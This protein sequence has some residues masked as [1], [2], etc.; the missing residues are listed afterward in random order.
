[1][2]RPNAKLDKVMNAYCQRQSRDIK[3]IRFHFD[4]QRIPYGNGD[5]PDTVSFP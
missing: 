3:S 4:G 1:M 2:I 5:T